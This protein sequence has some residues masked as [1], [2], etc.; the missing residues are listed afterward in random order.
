[1]VNNQTLTIKILSTRNGTQ[2]SPRWSHHIS[3][4]ERSWKIRYYLASTGPGCPGEHFQM[5]LSFL[6]KH[7]NTGTH[8]LLD[9]IIGPHKKYLDFPYTSLAVGA[10]LLDSLLHLSC[11]VILYSQWIDSMARCFY[12]LHLDSSPLKLNNRWTPHLGWSERWSG[13][14]LSWFSEK[15]I[16]LAHT[17]LRLRKATPTVWKTSRKEPM[18]LKTRVL[19]QYRV[20]ETGTLQF[21]VAMEVWGW[22]LKKKKKL[23]SDPPF[24]MAL[25][26]T[27]NGPIRCP[28]SSM[29]TWHARSPGFHLQDRKTNK[30]KPKG[31]ETKE[32]LCNN[33]SDSYSQTD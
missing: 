16:Q 23:S 28:Q 31:K 27:T 32:I 1:M 18:V 26:S 25:C 20:L 19:N 13:I 24:K 9:H 14:F 2:T 5:E 22:K 12:W 7:T 4:S 10:N 11:W 21:P 30:Q 29:F 33:S 15:H 8:S 6:H 17:L 3:H